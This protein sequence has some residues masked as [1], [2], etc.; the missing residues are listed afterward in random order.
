MSEQLRPIHALRVTSRG[1]GPSPISGL[2]LYLDAMASLATAC[3]RYG[4]DDAKSI[5]R[6]FLANASTFRGEKAKA[7]KAELKLHVG[8]K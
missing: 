8:I 3:D 4:L 1:S 2:C 5:V 6:Y 7:L